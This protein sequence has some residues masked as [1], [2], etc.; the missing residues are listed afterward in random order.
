MNFINTLNQG[1][2]V[3]EPVDHPHIRLLADIFHMLRM[4]EGPKEILRFGHLLH[5]VHVAEKKNRTPPGAEGDDFK[6]YFRALKDVGYKGLISIECR[7]SDMAKE[8]PKAIE[9]L[10]H[11]MANV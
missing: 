3:V 6:P 10:K 7:W 9:T 5:H 8:L 11:Q 4:E 2:R 1:A